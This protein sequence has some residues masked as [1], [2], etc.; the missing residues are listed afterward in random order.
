M[1]FTH[2]SVSHFGFK[3]LNSMVAIKGIVLFNLVFLSYLFFFIH[4]AFVKY[5]YCSLVFF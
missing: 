4:I 2:S 1:D 3:N 5:K